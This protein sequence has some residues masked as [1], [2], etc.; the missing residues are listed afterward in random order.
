MH[1]KKINGKQIEKNNLAISL[2]VLYTQNEKIYPA[3][4][5]KRK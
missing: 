4:I 2:H 5:L 1:Q 3:Y